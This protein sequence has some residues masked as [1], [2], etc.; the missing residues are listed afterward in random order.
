M[1]NLTYILHFLHGILSV[2]FF[3]F[4]SLPL[5]LPI[6]LFLHVQ[7][8]TY[9]FNYLHGILSHTNRT[10]L[11]IEDVDNIKK[12]QEWLLEGK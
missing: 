6:K 9:I 11:K 7:Y 5:S 8:L 12:K 4:L 10:K 1:S 2:F 3:F